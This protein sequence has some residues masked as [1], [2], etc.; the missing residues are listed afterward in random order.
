MF[1]AK[2]F[3]DLVALMLS[4]TEPALFALFA[5]FALAVDMARYR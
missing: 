4:L 3:N 2:T 1:I 5:L